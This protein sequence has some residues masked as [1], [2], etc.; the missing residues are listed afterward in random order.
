MWTQSS[1][2]TAV[3]GTDGKSCIQ[4]DLEIPEQTGKTRKNFEWELRAISR[5]RGSDLDAIFKIPV[6]PSRIT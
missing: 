4:V 5:L 6:F 3:V 1:T 2:A